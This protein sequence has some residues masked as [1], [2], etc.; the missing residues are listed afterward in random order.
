MQTTIDQISDR[1]YRVSTC[2]PQIAPGGFTFN[3]FLL[4]ADE[5][6]LYHTGMRA[7]F[8]AVREAVEK[9]MP[10]PRLRWIAFA[11]LEADE[12]GAVKSS[13]TP[14]R[15][16]RSPMERS[17]ACCPWTTS[18][19]GRRARWPTVRSSSSAAPRSPAGS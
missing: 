9:V 2:I 14:L 6:L 3:Q 8:P 15:M 18:A 11:H 16:L 4:D 12:C 7:L 1:I 5:P 17:A 19:C 13:S 10:L